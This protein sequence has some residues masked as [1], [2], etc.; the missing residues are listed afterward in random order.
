MCCNLH[1]ALLAVEMYFASNI[2]NCLLQEDGD[3]FDCNKK[4]TSTVNIILQLLLLLLFGF[5][6]TKHY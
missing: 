4:H 5:L 2:F 3:N 6:K 1:L